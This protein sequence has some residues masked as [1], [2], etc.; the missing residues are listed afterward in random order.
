MIEELRRVRSISQSCFAYRA[1]RDETFAL[2]GLV[3][4]V[5]LL[6]YSEGS[7]YL[8]YLSIAPPHEDFYHTH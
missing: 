5:N 2:V 4:N 1:L 3:E 8:L 7:C 6:V